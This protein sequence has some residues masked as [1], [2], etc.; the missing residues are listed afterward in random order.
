M[1][2]TTSLLSDFA[3]QS[4]VMLSHFFDY[5]LA[6]NTVT[7]RGD[8]VAGATAGIIQTVAEFW[9]VMSTLLF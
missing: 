6:G 9:A 3:G 4:L 2:D 1:W 7:P 8:F 5:F